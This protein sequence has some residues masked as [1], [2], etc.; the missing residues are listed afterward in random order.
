MSTDKSQGTT[1]R[2][3]CQDILS[4]IVSNLVRTDLLRWTN[5]DRRRKDTFIERFTLD[6]QSF[7]PFLEDHD[8]H[9]SF[10][11]PDPNL[12]DQP[13]E[14]ENRR[15]L[16]FI[17]I[18]NACMRLPINALGMGCLT[19]DAHDHLVG[20]HGE[21]LKLAALV[22]SRD[23]Y[24]VSITASGCNWRFDMHTDASVSC[25][26][27]PSQ[28]TK[29]IEWTDPALDMAS[30]RYHVG[31]DVAVVIGATRAKSGRP[32]A[33]DAFVNWLRL[34]TMDI[35]GLTYP[36]GIISTP[37]GDLILDPQLRGQL[38]HNGITLTN[39]MWA[40]HSSSRTISP[41]R[42]PAAIDADWH[43]GG[44]RLAKCNRQTTNTIRDSLGKRPTR[45]PDTLWHML[46][47]HCPIR[48]VEEH[49][50]ELFEVAKPCTVPDTTF[51]R[52]VDRALRACLALLKFTDHIQVVYIRGSAGNVDVY[53][54]KGQGTL[55]IHCRWL[56]FACMH[57]RSFCRPWSP[58]KL[59]DPN[60]PFF[61]CHV[62]EELLVRSIASMFKAH[63]T[64]R[65]A[66]M[67]FMC[68]IG[69]R[70]RYLP[71]SIKLKPYRGAFWSV[72]KT[73]R[74][75]PFAR[76]APAAQTIMLC[77]MKVIA[78]VAKQRFSTIKQPS[79]ATWCPVAAASSSLVKHT[80]CASLPVCLTHRHIMP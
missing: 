35:R 4:G 11:V 29:S 76:S 42:P 50:Q 72:G 40:A 73:M 14:R 38:Y 41:I 68:Q 21:G 18:A 54:D 2:T 46:R 3:G 77:C 13:A 43:P 62:V 75:N 36:A 6:R 69:R 48:T 63:P 65:P 64:S 15:A 8:D 17:T 61:C 25:T 79:P 51:A 52:A 20:R 34:T 45:L 23:S 32:V 53:F 56:D 27:A 33:L 71:H 9:L 7:Q 19:K 49:L 5:A 74:R 22:L 39:S 67:K 31:R 28:K 70:L 57:H 80:E 24:N 58:S 59:A 66:E 47:T 60:A 55:K 1:S 12:A 16:G 30:V 37:H 26:V 10:V 44:M 78:Q